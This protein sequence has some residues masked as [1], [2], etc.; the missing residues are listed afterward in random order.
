[1]Y[2]FFSTC[3][4]IVI[5]VQRLSLNFRYRIILVITGKAHFGLRNVILWAYGKKISLKYGYRQKSTVST[6][7]LRIY[8]V[9]T[10]DDTETDNETYEMLK[11]MAS[12]KLSRCSVNTFIQFCVSHFN[13]SCYLSRYW[14]WSRSVWKHHYTQKG[15]RWSRNC[16]ICMIFTKWTGNATETCTLNCT[17]FTEERHYTLLKKIKTFLTHHDIMWTTDLAPFKCH[18]YKVKNRKLTI[19]EICTWLKRQYNLNYFPVWLGSVGC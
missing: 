19:L 3:I 17:R 7:E 2:H 18:V 4:S 16:A 8:V 13:R 5:L 14:F 11:P 12:V 15:M 9:F 6:H 10:L 1:M